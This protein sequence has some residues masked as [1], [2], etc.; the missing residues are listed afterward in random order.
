V[1]EF[2]TI[3]FCCFTLEHPFAIELFCSPSMLCSSKL[4]ATFA[5]CY[6]S[7]FFAI[8]ALRFCLAFF[9]R[10]FHR[11]KKMK[12]P[13]TMACGFFFKPYC[14]SMEIDLTYIGFEVATLPSQKCVV[15]NKNLHLKYI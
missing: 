2:E 8:F 13:S 11:D 15:N 12:L 14:C 9:F 5:L 6:F 1:L 3:L 10:S 7:K 4:L